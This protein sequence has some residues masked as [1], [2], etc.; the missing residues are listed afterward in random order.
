VL[1]HP[2]SAHREYAEHGFVASAP[3]LAVSSFIASL[4][5]PVIAISVLLAATAA[6]GEPIDTATRLLAAI[7]LLL[8]FPGTNRFFDSAS[9]AAFD[10]A[11][12][13]FTVVSVL[14]LCGY[15]TNTLRRFEDNVL[16]AWGIVT[17]LT[18]IAFTWAG[19]AWL[20]RRARRHT[21]DHRSLIIGAGA[22]GAKV[23]ELLATRSDYGHHC[24]GYVEDRTADRSHPTTRHQLLG[25]FDELMTLIRSHNV[26]EVYFTLPLSMQPRIAHLLTD[27]RDSAV[28]IYFVP[29]LFAFSVIQGRMRNLKGMPVVSLLESPFVGVNALVKR[30]S[31][32]VLA[33]LIL[34]LI[35]PVMLAV[36]I[37]VKRSS[38]GPVIFKQRRNGLDGGEIIVWK[39]RSMTVTENGANV[40][41]ATRNDPRVTRVGAFIRR[42]SL[43]ELPQFFNVLQGSMSIVGPRPHAVAHNEMYRSLIRAYMIR[44]KVKPGITGLAQVNGYRGETPQ[45]EKMAGRVEY[46]IEYLRRWS[47]WLDITIIARTIK[48]CVFDRS[49]Y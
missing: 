13:W 4:L 30:L 38:P 3:P 15:A 34:V 28:T 37:A 7:T 11:A 49:A 23:G 33:S 39:F 14:L 32:V 43:D 9:R 26:R 2:A 27:L 20:R 17:P 12:A 48:L 5:E 16:L 6:L 45:L 41:Q 22:L 40:T 21:D 24:I 42:T 29:D 47:L 31:D 19:S 10:I 25:C 44:H 1:Q 36:A 8:L 46:D 35:S 18:Q